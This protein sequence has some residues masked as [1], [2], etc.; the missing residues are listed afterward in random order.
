MTATRHSNNGFK[1]ILPKKSYIFSL[2]GSSQLESLSSFILMFHFMESIYEK[3]SYFSRISRD[4]FTPIG[5]PLCDVTQLAVQR[6]SGNFKGVHIK[7][8]VAFL[9]FI[10]PLRRDGI[11]TINNILWTNSLDDKNNFLKSELFYRH[12]EYCKSL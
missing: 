1:H 6:S 8:S 4:I 12:R 5:W 9:L 2:E 10:L 3:K 7:A 11:F